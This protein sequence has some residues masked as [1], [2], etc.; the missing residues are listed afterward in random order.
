MRLL[1]EESF[2]RI[3][4]LI[5][6]DYK[7]TRSR[8][9]LLLSPQD[10]EVF[11][12]VDLLPNRGKW[13]A[14]VPGQLMPYSEASAAEREQIAAYLE[15]K[16]RAIAAAIGDKVPYVNDLFR[17]PDENQIF[18]FKDSTG[19]VRVVLS[20][21]GFR[22][23]NA[24]GDVDVIEFLISQPRTMSICEVVAKGVYSDG[25]P[26]ACQPITL[27]IF[28]N[29]S[30]VK[31]ATDGTYFIGKVPMNK[32]FSIT[33]D[34]QIYD[35]VTSADRESYD[36]IVNRYT[37][38][39]VRVVGQKGESVANYPVKINGRDCMTDADG[40][41][42]ADNVMMTGDDR[43]QVEAEYGEPMEYTL[44]PVRENNDF[45]Y[46]VTLPVKEEV[47]PPL[48]P[49][50]PE[51]PVKKPVRVHLLDLDGSP[52]DFVDV[53]IDQPNGTTVTATTDADGWATFPRDTFVDKKKSK[54][55]FKL[56][57]EYQERRRQMKEQQKQQQ[58]SQNHG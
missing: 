49:V 12:Q 46:R 9:A 4:P 29:T 30:E 26:Y 23:I 13:V 52:L 44:S 27:S 41:I 50:P 10:C 51:P 45:E 34:G 56:T 58:T 19:N 42:A 55:R 17:I 32:E 1:S 16:K 37:G 20:Q 35:F 36:F 33:A 24:P 40:I 47:K 11:A 53:F 39:S 2:S 8:L 7:R 22:R 48:P 54:L 25:Q 21:W 15:D 31:T 57:K 18:W 3:E 28:G 6:D 38:W 43:L 14:D 5:A